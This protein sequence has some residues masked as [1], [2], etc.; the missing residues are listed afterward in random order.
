[1]ARTMVLWA[2]DWPIVAVDVPASVPAVVLDKGSVL[3]CSQAARAEGVR[4][5]MRRR[6][7]QSRCP[8]LV[9]HDYNPDA[10][11]R[12][13]E[14]VLTAIEELSPGV[15]PLRPG[16]CAINVPARFYGGEAEAAAVIAER[17]VGLGCGTS[18][19]A[20]PTASSPPS[21]PLVGRLPRTASSYLPVGRRSSCVTCRSTPSTT[22]PSWDCC[23]AWGC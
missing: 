14:T 10:D 7:A 19:P 3:A 23:V 4:R 6:D 5:G 12:A 9:L 17:L 18:G 16:L 20:S 1:M 11:A 21:R 15:A 8:G 2:P 13:F 22:S